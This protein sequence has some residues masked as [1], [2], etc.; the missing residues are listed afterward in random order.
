[1]EPLRRVAH[2]CELWSH[3]WQ[4]KSYHTRDVDVG[5][6]PE[7]ERYLSSGLQR[8]AGQCE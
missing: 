2:M 4:L 3:E 6:M 7:P 1:M 8:P 5:G